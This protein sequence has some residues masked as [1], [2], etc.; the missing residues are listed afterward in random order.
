MDRLPDE[1][2]AKIFSALKA[3]NLGR[4]LQ[5]SKR[6]Y[7]IGM[8][9]YVWSSIE[10]TH[11]LNK[12]ACMA[13]REQ[14]IP[15]TPLAR[16]KA[17]HDIKDNWI[18]NISF[19]EWKQFKLNKVYISRYNQTNDISAVIDYVVSTDSVH[20]CVIFNLPVAKKNVILKRLLHEAPHVKHIEVE[21]QVLDPENMKL[22]TSFP[23]DR[24]DSLCINIGDIALGAIDLFGDLHVSD[25]TIRSDIRSYN[26]PF[27]KIAKTLDLN[28]NVEVLHL[29]SCCVDISRLKDVIN[30]LNYTL[31]TIKL[32]GPLAYVDTSLMR[33]IISTE[34]L[35]SFKS[36]GF[37]FVREYGQNIS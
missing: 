1:V 25:L 28:V 32:R 21:L 36:T 35:R 19:D 7:N 8:S 33:Q 11:Y 30:S 31:F 17:A 18:N 23:S 3:K 37:S 10:R 9:A 29:H 34:N 2:L 15:K 12:L 6:F 20:T 13:A 24:L 4:V 26:T 5:V 27:I 16:C 22:L 14:Y